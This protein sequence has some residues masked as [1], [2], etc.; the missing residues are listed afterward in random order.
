MDQL[1]PNLRKRL[2]DAVLDARSVAET[3][4][5]AA[6]E[7]LAVGAAEAF[8]EMSADER[9]LRNRLR[10][11]GR[12][13][14]DVRDAKTGAQTI[15][16]LTA[17]L[18]Y[19]YW[20]RM[21]FARFL[22]ENN[23]LMHPEGVAVTL[24]ECEELAAEEGA[25]N[26]FM[27]AARYA[28]RM[29]PQIFRQDAPVLNVQFAPEHRRELE[30]LL[31]NLPTDMFTAFDSLGWVYQFWQAKKKKEIN[32]SEVKI[33]AREL[34]AVTQLFTEPYM[35]SFLLD[36]SLGAWWAA[37]RLS[38]TDLRN[39]ASE[40]ELRGRAAI[41]GVSLEYLRFVRTETGAWTPAAGTFD[42]W[43]EDLSELK[44]LDPCCGSGHFLVAAFLMLVPMRMELERLSAREAVDAVLRE[45][46]HG[47]EIDQRCV[48]LAA[49][50]LALTAWRYPNAGGYRRLP[51]LNVACSG[52]AIGAK[53]EE[54]LALAGDNVNL[55]TALDST[56][57]IL[58]L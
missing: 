7:R 43:A 19:E 24:E 36:N 33:G 17:E 58:G 23:L 15:D 45:N 44:T 52:L 21:L 28:S 5:R 55:R 38:E 27:L 53:K 13:L 22:G 34:P 14:G 10:A 50:A 1:H 46:L 54:W 4:A 51:E 26:G 29:L 41:A 11:H 35:V 9:S 37:R 25:A 31:N 12:Q 2:E 56:L 3:G 20:H 39:A 47:L 49:F 42:S 6:L 32:A 40:E 30:K 57:S 18:A 8:K 16:K 48:E